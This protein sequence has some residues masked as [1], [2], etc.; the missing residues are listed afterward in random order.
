MGWNNQGV[1][2]GLPICRLRAIHMPPSSI[3]NMPLEQRTPLAV[4]PQDPKSQH[5]HTLEANESERNANGTRTQKHD[6]RHLLASHCAKT[7][8]TENAP[9]G[10]TRERDCK[11]PN[12][13]ETTE[14]TE[15]A[16]RGHT[17]LSRRRHIHCDIFTGVLTL[18]TPMTPILYQKIIII[19][20]VFLP[21]MTDDDT[22]YTD[23]L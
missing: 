23:I 19:A 22:V 10:V 18:M 13:T 17:T 21:L 12:H 9:R 20:S 2:L 14:N 16:K 5:Q 3:A 6:N 1:G 7:P 11:T 4:H 15:I 8:L